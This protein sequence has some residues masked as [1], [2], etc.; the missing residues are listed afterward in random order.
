MSWTHRA[1]RLILPNQALIA[2]SERGFDPE[3]WECA[4]N[5]Y[6]V[7]AMGGSAARSC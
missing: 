3:T 1:W 7:P 6:F 2:V 5:Q 4:L